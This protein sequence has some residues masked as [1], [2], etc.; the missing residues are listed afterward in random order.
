[1]QREM[2]Y[3]QLQKKKLRDFSKSSQR[4]ESNSQNKSIEKLSELNLDIEKLYKKYSEVK[5]ERL[6]KE[7]T[8]QILV[9]RLKVLHSQHNSSKNKDNLRKSEKYKKIHV[10]INSKYKNI[11]NNNLTLRRYRFSEKMKNNEIESKSNNYRTINDNNNINILSNTNNHNYSNKDNK[12]YNNSGNDKNSGTNNEN[13]NINNIDDFLKKYRY[14][15]GNKNSNNNIYIIINNP[16]NYPDK[17]S[18]NDFNRTPK[19]K[20]IN[21]IVLKNEGKIK[22][23]IKS[24]INIDGEKI[25][26]TFEY[27]T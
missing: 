27:K 7:K 15:I 17:K 1:M 11:N 3:F 14:N 26:L 2:S 9:N 22:K 6:M 18:E 10:K 12:S 23:H 13:N 25:I 21:N 16:N 19:P 20:N 5:K 8:Q 24:D 4:R